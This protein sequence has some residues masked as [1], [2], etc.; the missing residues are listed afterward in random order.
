MGTRSILSTIQPII[1]R[2]F[3]SITLPAFSLLFSSS[4]S[5]SSSPSF[6]SCSSA[7]VVGHKKN[8]SSVLQEAAPITSV[9]IIHSAFC[10]KPHNGAGEDAHLILDLNPICSSKSTWL[11][12]VFDGVGSW[13]FEQGIDVSK[14]SRAICEATINS[15]RQSAQNLSSTS[16]TTK[17]TELLHQA[18][19]T[20]REQKIVGS[21]TACI[22]SISPDQ[23][24]RYQLHSVSVGDSGFLVLRR[25]QQQ[26][27]IQSE[28]QEVN[29]GKRGQILNHHYSNG[30]IIIIIFF[31]FLQFHYSILYENIE[32]SFIILTVLFSWVCLSHWLLI[33]L[34]ALLMESLFLSVIFRMEI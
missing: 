20:V 11:L 31:F 8:S 26:P 32:N 5:S 6:S 13:S 18:W 34:I 30:V 21:C 15:A 22:V 10:V 17:L 4:S 19:N 7:S 12:G 27:L 1:Y 14:Y 3:S 29:H 24:G 25:N 9:P 23:Q 16:T 33:N 28:I 2:S